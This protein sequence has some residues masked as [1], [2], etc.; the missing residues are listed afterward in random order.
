MKPRTTS[1][2]NLRGVTGVA[3]SLC[4]VARVEGS[5]FSGLGLWGM[6]HA[7]ARDGLGQI[8]AQGTEEWAMRADRNSPPCMSYDSPDSVRS[9]WLCALR[10][11]TRREAYTR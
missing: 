5:I 2:V 8:D 4:V 10:A 1:S 7:D 6:M 11:H 3:H 9:V